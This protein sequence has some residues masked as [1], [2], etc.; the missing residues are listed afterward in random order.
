MHLWKH[1]GDNSSETTTILSRQSNVAIPYL[2]YAIKY[3]HSFPDIS[4]FVL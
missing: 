1:N 2:A 4:F 3:V